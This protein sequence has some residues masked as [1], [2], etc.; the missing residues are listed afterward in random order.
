MEPARILVAAGNEVLTAKL[1]AVLM[2]DGYIVDQVKEGNEC[3]RKMRSLK[4]DLAVLDYNL[5]PANGFEVAKIAIE[6]KLSDILLVVSSEQKSRVSDL[7]SGYDLAV[8]I[9]PFNRDSFL[10]TVDLI[11]KNR[12][13]IIK[14]EQE[15]GELK[16]TL[17]ARKEIEK[18]KGLLM[19]HLNLSEEDAFRRIQKQSM[20][21]GI[22]MKEIAKAIILT[23]DI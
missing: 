4:P 17:N 2:E 22:P 5:P 9:K 6:D 11:I 19:K 8:I 16:T 23:Y 21:R 20:D 15:I 13:K 18:A 3:L 12:K 14:L 10:S 1:K 7:R